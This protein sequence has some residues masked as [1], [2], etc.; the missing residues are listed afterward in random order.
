MGILAATGTVRLKLYDRRFE[1][2]GLVPVPPRPEMQEL[3]MAGVRAIKG[4][5]RGPDSRLDTAIA[6][7]VEQGA[8]V[9]VLGC[10]EIPLAVDAEAQPIP[11]VDATTVL[12]EGTLRMAGVTAQDWWSRDA[13]P[14][15][16]RAGARERSPSGWAS[17]CWR[18]WAASSRVRAGCS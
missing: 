14:S 13:A 15:S 6:E 4:G 5:H 1:E 9:L 17:T 16:F 2:A 10:T 18:A 7:L 3:V 12:I 11:V 8:E